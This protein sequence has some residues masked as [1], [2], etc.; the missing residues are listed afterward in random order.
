MNSVNPI[1][2]HQVPSVPD[3]TSLTGNTAQFLSLL[4]EELAWTDVLSQVESSSLLASPSAFTPTLL[5]TTLSDYL[6]GN[7]TM[8]SQLQSASPGL[9]STGAGTPTAPVADPAQLGSNPEITAI[10]DQ[11]SQKYG[12]PVNLILGVIQQESAMNPNAVSSAGAVGLMQLMPTTARGLGATNPF[13][14]V[15]NV[16]AGTHYLAIQ[17][18]R[19]QGNVQLALAAYNAGPGA[20]A[21]YHGV[22]PYPET[23][24]YIQKVMSYADVFNG[25]SSSP[26][27][28]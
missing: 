18:N 23:L 24:Q 10:V 17:L 13:D 27:G 16:M 25:S 15:Q 11:A 7:S 12:V 26:S 6:S 9:A 2:S 20:V 21:Q 1:Q 5:S 8:A 4:M 3:L 22:P 14:P 19:Y 28:V